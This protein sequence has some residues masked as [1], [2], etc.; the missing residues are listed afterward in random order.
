MGVE[1]VVIVNNNVVVIFII[2]VV[3]VKDCEVVVFW[4][5]LIEI[6]GSYCFFEVMLMSGVILC[7]IGII[8]KMCVFDYES[9]IGE[10]IGVLM[11]VY[12]SNFEIVGF[13]EFVGIDELVK[14]FKVYC[15]FV[16][17]DIGLGVLFDV[18]VYGFQNELVVKLS[19]LVGFDVVL[20]S[21]DKFV[22]GL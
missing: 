5:Y 1:V 2:L 9:V 13:M 4:G 17:D 16:I 12:L 14:I 21:G 8:N 3:F 6:G 15:I 19:I 20:F 7:E 22:G 18:D 10:Q 11:K